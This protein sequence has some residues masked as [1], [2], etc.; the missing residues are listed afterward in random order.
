MRQE[1]TVEDN[2]NMAEPAARPVAVEVADRM[3]D[4]DTHQD[5]ERVK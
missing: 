1:A 3:L 2:S 4:F 5:T